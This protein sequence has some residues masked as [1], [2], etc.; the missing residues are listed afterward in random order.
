MALTDEELLLQM[1]IL[2]SKTSDNANMVYKS[3]A[4]LNKAL[5]PEFFSGNNSKIVNAINLLAADADKVKIAATDVANKVNDVLLDTDTTDNKPIWE[6]VQSLMGKSTI[7][8]GLENILTGNKQKEILGLNENDIG[9]YLTVAQDDKGQ[10]MVKAID[11]IIGG[12]S[13]PT[14]VEI[15]YDN[16]KN[17]EIIN[18][19]DALDYLF[20]NC[21]NN[22]NLIIPEN[23]FWEDIKNKP[24]MVNELAISEDK[25]CLMSE[26]GTVSSVDLTIDT[27]IDHII[28]GLD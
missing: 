7:I 14:A 21:S 26:D 20:T 15:P 12:G 10:L 27:D 16:E 2:A 5:N 9:K 28:N 1:N 17:P 24:A 4:A 6:H 23:I 3:N 11:T 18:V 13:I 22:G 19:K 8:E 25:L